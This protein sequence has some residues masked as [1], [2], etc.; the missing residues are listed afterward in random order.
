L[1]YAVSKVPLQAA[2]N[3]RENIKRQISHMRR[4]ASDKGFPMVSVLCAS[5]LCTVLGKDIGKTPL[6]CPIWGIAGEYGRIF[7]HMVYY[8]DVPVYGIF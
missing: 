2:G 3:E 7:F 1:N 8:T 5:K 6:S 4:K